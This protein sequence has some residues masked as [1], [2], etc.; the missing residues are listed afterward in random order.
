ML[1]VGNGGMTGDEYRTHMTLW[2]MLA[3]P[4]LAGNDLSRMTAETRSIL[5]NRDVIAVDQDAA[6]QQATR[7]WAE[8][9][10]EIWTKGLADGGT[11]VAL[12]NRGES[13]LPVALRVKDV[14]LRKGLQTQN[15]WAGAEIRL[16]DEQTFVIPRHGVVLL[17]VH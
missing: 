12:F 16:V 3:A 7:V 2:A 5:L 17:V 9:P 14:G 13:T 4:L 6:G 10:K 1:E 15:V 11:A 8:G